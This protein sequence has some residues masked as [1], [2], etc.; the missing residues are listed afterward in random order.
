LAVFISQHL[1]QLVDPG[2]A[3]GGLIPAKTQ[4]RE[5]PEVY[6]GCQLTPQKAPRTLKCT[7]DF[8]PFFIICYHR[9]VDCGECQFAID[10]DI[11]YRH[12]PKPRII[13]IALQQFSYLDADPLCQLSGA[14]LTGHARTSLHLNG[15]FGEAF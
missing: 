2:P 8:L 10:F 6:P 5:A 3:I 7:Q 13:D 15:F 12:T 1:K 4:L 14:S 11:R 9:D